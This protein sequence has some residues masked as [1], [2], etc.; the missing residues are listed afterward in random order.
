[1]SNGR[2]AGTSGET[3]HRG[4]SRARGDGRDFIRLFRTTRF[5]TYAL[6]ISAISRLIFSSVVGRGYLKP[7]K[8]K[9]QIKEGPLYLLRG[10]QKASEILSR[11]KMCITC[12]YHVRS[13]S[14]VFA[15][16]SN[17]P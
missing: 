11:N 17:D 1:M 7:R 5:Q 12:N 6:F 8:A 3:G 2:G 13:E 16:L 10:L 15:R 4:E 14:M 9:P